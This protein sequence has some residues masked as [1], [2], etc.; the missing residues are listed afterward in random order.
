MLALLIHVLLVLVFGS[1]PGGNSPRGGGVQGPL[2]V[3]LA[4]LPAQR[5]TDPG[6][7][8]RARVDISGPPAPRPMATLPR[9]APTPRPTD[10]PPPR[11]PAE[12]PQTVLEA[13]RPVPAPALPSPTPP[14]PWWWRTE[15]VRCA[16]PCVTRSTTIKA[17]TATT[18]AATA[19]ANARRD[20][21]PQTGRRL[22]T[23]CG[24]SR[25]GA[26]CAVSALPSPRVAL[27]VI[28]AK[29]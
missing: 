14:E 4:G 28:L 25:S 10:R 12:A 3:R 6:D 20:G 11:A 19:S 21:R 26:R 1:A 16:P 5:R 22:R 27:A 29:S 18:G 17:P 7:V 9:P 13:P 2:S 15:R 23:T 8:P 24:D